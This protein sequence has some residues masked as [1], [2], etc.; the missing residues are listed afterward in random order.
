VTPTERGIGLVI[1]VC[2]CDLVAW[3]GNDTGLAERA[4]G[5]LEG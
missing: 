4:F 5:G 2:G 3:D 1:Y